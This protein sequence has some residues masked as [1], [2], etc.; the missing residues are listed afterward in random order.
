MKNK[1]YH[2]PVLCL[3]TLLIVSCSKEDRSLPQGEEQWCV[4]FY[5]SA[6]DLAHEGFLMDGA[7][8]AAEAIEND[9]VAVTT[10]FKFA[11]NEETTSPDL[12]GTIRFYSEGNTLKQDETWRQDSKYQI[13]DPEHLSDFLRWS[14]AKY[15]NRRYILVV[16]GH[17]LAWRLNLDAP[18]SRSLLQ[19]DSDAKLMAAPDFALGLRQSGVPIDLIYMNVCQQNSI[20]TVVE[21]QDCA[22]YLMATSGNTPDLGSDYSCMVR[23]LTRGNSLLG[24]TCKVMDAAFDIWK[25]YGSI[26]NASSRI[27]SMTLTDLTRVGEIMVTLK[28]IVDHLIATVGD[29][30]QSTDYPAGPGQPFGYGYLFAAEDAANYTGK[31]DSEIDLLDCI[32]KMPVYSGNQKLLPLIGPF[33]EAVSHAIVH[34]NRTDGEKVCSYNILVNDKMVFDLYP[35]L[36]EAS[37]FDQAV[38][39]SR[40]LKYKH[41]VV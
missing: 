10:L 27:N 9:E 28:P 29:F 26:T 2:I 38:G 23:E 32:L 40:F 11:G 15:P 39:W 33:R 8:Q 3:L 7:R 18:K 14:S 24:T 16:G 17:G 35:Q 4:M 34:C 25:Y 22:H 13:T 21:L 12:A 19:E 20:E 36:Y 6:G 31:Q 1:F 41:L 37:R 5:F 30:G